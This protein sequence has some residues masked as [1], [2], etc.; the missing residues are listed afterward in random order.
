M[1]LDC[2]ISLNILLSPLAHDISCKEMTIFV[3]NLLI[4]GDCKDFLK[5]LQLLQHVAY[6]VDV[7]TMVYMQQLVEMVYLRCQFLFNRNNSSI[8]TY[9]VSYESL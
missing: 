2:V 8:S 1:Y 5:L 7:L 9:E 3:C 6:H 4:A